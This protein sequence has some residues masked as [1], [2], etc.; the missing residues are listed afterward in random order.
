MST[1]ATIATAIN[2]FLMDVPK[3][4]AHQVIQIF[5]AN[6]PITLNQ[7]WTIVN[8]GEGGL[9]GPAGHI[10][11][12]AGHDPSNHLCIDVPDAVALP[13]IFVQL[14][15]ATTPGGTKSQ[16]WKLKQTKDNNVY[17]ESALDSNLVLQVLIGVAGMPLQIWPKEKDQLNQLWLLNPVT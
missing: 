6:S 3:S 7:K 10:N 4:L 15:P 1:L 5:P 13:G 9:P 17:I 2:G 16:Q 8:L 14:L 11:I 12:F